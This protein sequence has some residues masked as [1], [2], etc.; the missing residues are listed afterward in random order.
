MYDLIILDINMPV[1]D[2][3]EACKKII[4]ILRNKS[5]KIDIK[6]RNKSSS[7]TKFNKRNKVLPVIVAVTGFLDDNTIKRIE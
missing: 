4:E 3:F 5:S 6:A 7:L 1:T 2:G